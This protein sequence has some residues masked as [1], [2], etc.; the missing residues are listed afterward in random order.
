MN[1]CFVVQTCKCNFSLALFKYLAFS[2]R[3][4]DHCWLALPFCPQFFPASWRVETSHRQWHSKAECEVSVCQMSVGTVGACM[5]MFWWRACSVI[6]DQLEWREECFR[7]AV[8]SDWCNTHIHVQ[9]FMPHSLCM[10]APLK[11]DPNRP[12]K[13]IK[14]LMRCRE[15]VANH[16]KPNHPN[17]WFSVF[18]CGGTFIEKIK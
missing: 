17:Q 1:H 15:C 16:I 6:F 3:S 7:I 11:Q 18:W 2:P 8:W 13:Y 4:F 9:P 14:R 10:T 5:C 12:T